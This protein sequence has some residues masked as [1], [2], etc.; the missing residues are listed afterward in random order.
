MRIAQGVSR[1]AGREDLGQRFRPIL[2]RTLRQLDEQASEEWDGRESGDMPAEGVE[3]SR[4]SE[5]V[6]SGEVVVL[7]S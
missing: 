7:S 1:L 6:E 2:R 5:A 4:V 3:A